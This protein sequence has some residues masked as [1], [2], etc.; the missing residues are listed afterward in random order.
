MTFRPYDR[1]TTPAVSDSRPNNTGGL[2]LKGTPVTINAIGE[3]AGVDVT[4]EASS[5][6]IVGVA[7]DNISNGSSGEFIS[8]GKI[9]DISTTGNF[10]DVMYVDKSGGLTATKPT[11]GLD[12]FVAGDLV[13]I[14]G[15]I[16][17]NTSNPALKD[18]VINLNIVGQL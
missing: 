4:V 13:I 1:I 9:A 7:T 8:S 10:G 12:G 5:L 2:I 17:K 14:V 15:V 16:A 18:L 11:I 6:N 3:L